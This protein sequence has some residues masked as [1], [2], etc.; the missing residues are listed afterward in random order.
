MTREGWQLAQDALAPVLA[1]RMH[2]AYKAANEFLVA[3]GV[4]KEIDLQSLVKRAPGLRSAGR[5]PPRPRADSGRDGAGVA[6][7][8]AR[9]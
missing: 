2:E 6:C 7:S 3:S 4:M 5:S 1:I 8:R 9:G